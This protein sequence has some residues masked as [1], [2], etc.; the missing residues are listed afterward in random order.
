MSYLSLHNVRERVELT[1]LALLFGAFL[2]VMAL[3]FI[4]PSAALAVFGLGLMAALTAIGIDQLLGRAE[5]RVA[6]KSLAG[7][8]CPR[9][10]A[11]I[12]WDG[13]GEPHWHCEACRAD[14]LPDGMEEGGRRDRPADSSPSR[15]APDEQLHRRSLVRSSRPAI[16]RRQPR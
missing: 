13:T 15:P 10:R 14:F 12:Q 1:M 6:R 8:V 11:P 5:R 3:M 4:H 2:L 7:H 9:C 16:H